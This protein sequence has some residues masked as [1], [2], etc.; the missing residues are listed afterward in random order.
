MDMTMRICN[1]KKRIYAKTSQNTHHSC[2]TRLSRKR[3]PPLPLRRQ[4]IRVRELNFIC[5]EYK[6]AYDTAVANPLNCEAL[7]QEEVCL[8]RFPPRTLHSICRR[9][10][11]STSTMCRLFSTAMAFHKYLKKGSSKSVKSLNITVKSSRSI[12]RWMIRCII[13]GIWTAP[14]RD[15]VNDFN[16][17]LN[18]RRDSQMTPVIRQTFLKSIKNSNTLSTS[19]ETFYVFE[20]IYVIFDRFEWN[21]SNDSID[22]LINSTM[23]KCTAQ[24]VAFLQFL[25]REL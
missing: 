5:K 19:S 4:P 21:I 2:M 14:L 17:A 15:F 22:R 9:N 12:T 24:V 8:S 6:A 23:L 7:L 1:K 10:L 25:S 13:V 16:D 20:D 3:T 11:E 18:V